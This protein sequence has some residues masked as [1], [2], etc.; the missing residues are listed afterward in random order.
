[1]LDL[2][3]TACAAA[4]LA[5]LA[6]PSLAQAQSPSPAGDGLLFRMSADTG[7]TS[8]VAAGQAEPTFAD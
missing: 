6:L 1:M 2:R 8:D 7:L 3:S 5:G 4:L